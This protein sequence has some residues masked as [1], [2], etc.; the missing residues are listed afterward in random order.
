MP[1]VTAAPRI[2]RGLGDR[3]G[4][5]RDQWREEVGGDGAPLSVAGILT[6]DSSS[7]NHDWL[8]RTGVSGCYSGTFQSLFPVSLHPIRVVACWGTYRRYWRY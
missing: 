5:T 4:S 7:V 3:N 8:G 6:P 1:A 2:V